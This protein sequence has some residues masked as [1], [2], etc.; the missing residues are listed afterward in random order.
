MFITPVMLKKKVK[1]E[2]KK[3]VKVI[4]KREVKIIIEAVKAKLI[5][6][7]RIFTIDGSAV[8]KIATQV[9]SVVKFANVAV[10]LRKV[11]FEPT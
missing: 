1:K 9:M 2:V 5:I 6:L 4:T 10:I 3:E 7:F 11:G 8:S